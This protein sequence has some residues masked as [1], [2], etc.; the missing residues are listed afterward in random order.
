V[1][2]LIA[3]HGFPPTHTGGA[4]RRAARTAYGLAAR[5]H[6]VAV[7][8]GESAGQQT[9]AGWTDADEAGVR[10]RRLHLG[11]GHDAGGG[12]AATYD[13]PQTARAMEDLI[14]QFQPDIVH[15]F[16]GY[17]L[18]ASVVRVA[19]RHALPVVVS[20]TDY[21][22]L[23]HRIN[24]IRTDGSRCA[25]PTPRDCARCQAETLRRFRLPARVWPNGAA[26]I[27]QAAETQP[28]LARHLGMPQQAKRA[29]TTL[30]TLGEVAA[31][32]APSQYLADFYVRHGIDADKVHVWRQGV[33]VHSCPVRCPSTAIRFGYLGQVKRHKG[34]DLILDAW[35]QLTG[36]RPRRLVIYGSDEGE[37]AYGQ[38][39]RDAIG[40]LRDVSWPGAYRG[41]EVWDNL[42]GLD[43]VVVPSRWVE[44][45]PNVILEAQAMGVPIIGSNL[46][47][48]A[49]LVQHDV[50]GLQFTVDDAGDLARQM[51]RLLDDSPLLA[52]IR[53]RQVPFRTVDMEIDEI[54]GL[55]RELLAGRVTANAHAM[56]SS[57][58]AQ[59]Q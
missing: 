59:T 31:F 55:Y 53:Q 32:I 21:W 39:L 17:L 35:G 26:A 11:T 4:E 15:L 9:Q 34:V 45:S 56:A 36:D 8:C 50:N 18:S 28:F 38:R 23:C 58:I 43:V 37:A 54:D 49:E 51:Q 40:R 20:L 16:S 5:G 12:F 57:L 1:R 48:V 19:S 27:W 14:A 13:N 3:V 30:S 6:D 2:I 41:N 29:A 24:L 52:R 47:G 42:A 44:N 46:G 7:L 25:G 22:W 10:V 33:D